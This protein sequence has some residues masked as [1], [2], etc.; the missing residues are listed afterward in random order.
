MSDDEQPYVTGVER[1]GPRLLWWHENHETWLRARGFME[2][3]C[4]CDAA[5]R[6]IW[7]ATCPL[8]D[9]DEPITADSAVASMWRL[10]CEAGHVLMDGSE[11]ADNSVADEHTP[12]TTSEI[13]RRL[14]LPA[15]IEAW[16]AYEQPKPPFA[17]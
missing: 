8:L 7:E 14:A 15:D 12:P 11:L 3:T 16:R 1:N 13:V 10:E 5:V 17:R 2:W 6:V 9:T 4:Y